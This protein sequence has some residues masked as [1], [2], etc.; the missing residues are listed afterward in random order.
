MTFILLTRGYSMTYCTY[1]DDLTYCTYTH[2]LLCLHFAYTRLQHDFTYWRAYC[3]SDEPTVFWRLPANKT[4]ASMR[5]CCMT[6]FTCALLTIYVLPANKTYASIRACLLHDLLYLRTRRMQE[7]LCT[8]YGY[9]R[10]RISR[11]CIATRTCVSNRH[12]CWYS[13][14]V[15][16]AHIPR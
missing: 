8:L 13:C 5:A 7:F 11:M 9:S 15:C 12:V 1:P 3:I 14:D 2:D 4:Y 6:C 10:V 16:N